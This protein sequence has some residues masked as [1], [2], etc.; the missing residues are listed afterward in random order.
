[1]NAG[2][3]VDPERLDPEL[4]DRIFLTRVI[5]PGDEA[6]GRWVRECGVREVARRLRADG[7]AL[8]GVS[9]RRWAGL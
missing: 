3:A 5:E 9:A 8:P 1:M 4:L 6:G 2:E 7:P